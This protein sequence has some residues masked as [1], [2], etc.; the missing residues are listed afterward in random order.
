[1]PNPRVRVYLACSVDGFIAGADD[2][3]TWLEPPDAAARRGREQT[4]ALTY[5]AFIGDVGAILMGR[6]TYDVVLGFD[7]WPYGEMPVL[8]ATRRPLALVRASVT[9]VSGDI[10][11]LVELGLEAARGK[12]L[13]VDG[14]H[15]VRDALAANLV[16]EL[17]LTIVP[18]LLGSGVRLFT[19]SLQRRALKFTHH[20]AFG[21][22]V[23]LT[24]VRASA[25]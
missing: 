11:S 9:A 5:D 4:D 20:A 24:A 21:D 14:A 18:V 3:L 2:D 6:R 19:D 15:L 25:Q 10:A 23:Q 22:M 7:R 1:M 12:D 16:D 17:V 13:Y 8:V